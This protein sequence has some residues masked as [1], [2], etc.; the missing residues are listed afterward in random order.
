MEVGGTQ[1]WLE[2]RIH[3]EVHMQFLVFTQTEYLI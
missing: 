2:P 3:S 1:S